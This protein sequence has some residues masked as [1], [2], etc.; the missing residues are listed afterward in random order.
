MTIKELRKQLDFERKRTTR[1]L[2]KLIELET[3]V[4]ALRAKLTA[5][6]EAVEADVIR[7]LTAR[8][9]EVRRQPVA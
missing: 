6:H 1:Y 9:H 5:P 3:E 8:G 2:G 4:D 7:W